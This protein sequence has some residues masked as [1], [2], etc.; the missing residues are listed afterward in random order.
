M[1]KSLFFIW[2]FLFMTLSGYAQ[3]KGDSTLVSANVRNQ[4]PDSLFVGNKTISFGGHW[5]VV[6]VEITKGEF[7]KLSKQSLNLQAKSVNYGKLSSSWKKSINQ[8]VS[9]SVFDKPIQ[10]FRYPKLGLTEVRFPQGLY[11]KSCMGMD[12]GKLDSVQ[13]YSYSRALSPIGIYAG[14]ESQDCDFYASVDFYAYDKVRQTMKPLFRYEDRRFFSE[15]G[16]E[17]YWINSS[18]LVVAGYSKGNGT[19]WGDYVTK[20]LKPKNTPV[21]YKWRLIC[22]LQPLWDD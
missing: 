15:G 3:G 6:P 17:M 20:G 5:L 10:V 18:E 14:E 19:N 21:Y 7:D 1:K 12:N 9:T 11:I 13:L 4:Y 16:L 8:L 22:D 2:I